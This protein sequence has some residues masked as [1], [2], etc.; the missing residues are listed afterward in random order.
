MLH[1]QFQVLP[2][3]LQEPKKDMQRKKITDNKEDFNNELMYK[4][5]KRKS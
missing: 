5:I 2:K 3:V 1:V 4:F